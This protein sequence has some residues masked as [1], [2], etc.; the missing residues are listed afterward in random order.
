MSRSSS[1]ARSLKG[2]DIV[3][4][5]TIIMRQNSAIKNMACKK[6]E[7]AQNEVMVTP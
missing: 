7:E 3:T 1:K 2:G 6:E 4:S 5:Q